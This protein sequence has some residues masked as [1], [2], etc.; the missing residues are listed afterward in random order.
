MK[1]RT[2][3]TTRRPFPMSR[4]LA[5]LLLALATLLPGIA[6][7]HTTLL[8]SDPADG[9]VSLLVVRLFE[10][11][12]RTHANLLTDRR[13]EILAVKLPA[14]LGRG[15]HVLS[16]RATSGDGHPISG[17]LTFSVGAPSGQ[18][19]DSISTQDDGVRI[20]LWLT[21]LVL[22]LGLF[23][24]AGGV[25]FLTWIAP[26]PVDRSRFPALFLLAGLLALA[27]SVGLQGVDAQGLHW[28]AS[29]I[30]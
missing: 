10:A 14:D 15:S 23:I 30:R 12:G 24:G 20:A 29:P 8:H 27:G 13:S 11:S 2:L 7:A 21:R 4:L 6:W 28:A 18:A 1:D 3:R 17:S 16:Y 9:Q 26:Q 22:H 19:A 25:F 5:L